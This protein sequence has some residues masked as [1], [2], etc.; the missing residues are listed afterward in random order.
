[1]ATFSSKQYSWCE[2]SVV[3]GSRILEGITGIE[4]TEKQEKDYLYG[5]GCKP[6]QIV[7]GN[8]TCD[9]KIKIWQSELEAM[10]CDAPNKD[11]LQLE[12]NIT[13]AYV[14]KDGGQTVIDIL[15]GVQ[16]TEIGKAINQGDKN[17]IVELPIMFLDVDRQE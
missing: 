4:Y 11:V 7:S 5:R 6:H 8:K 12:F 14:P 1:M 13:I 2:V 17:M 9:G 3:Y 10:I 15:K 16:I